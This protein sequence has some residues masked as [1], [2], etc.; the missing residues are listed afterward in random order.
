MDHA[1]TPS[2]ESVP[3]CS[4]RPEKISNRSINC[5][6]CGYTLA[7]L[8]GARCPECGVKFSDDWL[9]SAD[10]TSPFAQRWWFAGRIVAAALVCIGIAALFML[11]DGTCGCLAVSVLG[12]GF[13]AWFGRWARS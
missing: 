6:V 1:N 8:A 3:G 7:G 10:Y 4:D 2:E 13:L 12:T 5:P 9:Y 11:G